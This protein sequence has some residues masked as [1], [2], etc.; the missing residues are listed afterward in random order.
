MSALEEVAAERKRQ[1]EV[2]G[3]TP[4]HDDTHTNGELALAACAYAMPEHIR[5]FFDANDIKLWP[6][7][8]E[9]N[10][11]DR[12]RDLVRAGALILAEI[13]RVRRMD[14]ME[15]PLCGKTETH[16]HGRI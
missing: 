13:D 2:E 12:I 9:I 16:T 6:F 11:K 1:V 15:C 5:Q 14:Q 8:G 10:F 7:E 4:A 3:W